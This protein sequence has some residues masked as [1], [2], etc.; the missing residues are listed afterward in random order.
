MHVLIT[1][2]RVTTKTPDSYG[3]INKVALAKRSMQ[4]TKFADYNLILNCSFLVALLCTEL[5][6]ISFINFI[7]ESRITVFPYR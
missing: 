7:S 1:T 4:I 3:N 5:N 2:S 6:Y